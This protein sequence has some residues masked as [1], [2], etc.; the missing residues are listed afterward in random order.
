[1]NIIVYVMNIS[2]RKAKYMIGGKHRGISFACLMFMLAAVLL[3]VPGYATIIRV[4]SMTPTTGS[5]II[6]WESDKGGTGKVIYGEGRRMKYSVTAEPYATHE[7][8]S[9]KKVTKY[10]AYL[11]KAVLDRLKPGTTYHYIVQIGR[12]ASKSQSFMTGPKK[13]KKLTFVAYGDSR[14][15]PTVHAK[16]AKLYNRYKP[17]F[18]MHCGDFVQR[19]HKYDRWNRDFFMPLS[20]ILDH[21]P[22]IPTKGNHER[23]WE[24]M[25]KVM[26]MP[27]NEM[28]AAYWLEY[29]D[30]LHILILRDIYDDNYVKWAEKKLSSSRAKWKIAMGHYPSFNMGGH[31]ET[32]GF[33]E[34][35]NELFKKYRVDIYFSGDSHLYERFEPVV[36]YNDKSSHVVTYIVT[37]GGGASLYNLADNS[38][39]A[40]NKAIYHFVVVDI[41]GNT[42]TLRAID[43]NGKEFDR[44]VIKKNNDGTVTAAYRAAAKP[45]EALITSCQ[46]SSKERR[47]GN[48]YARLSSKPSPGKDIDMTF[49]FR[50]VK[51]DKRDKVEVTIRLSEESRKYYTM[52]PKEFSGIVQ[53][54]KTFSTKL[55]AKNAQLKPLILECSYKLIR[56]GKIYFEGTVWTQDLLKVS[57]IGR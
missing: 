6:C 44:H 41:D 11:Y 28:E 14:D 36:P 16:L 20:G 27:D 38:L 43:Q 47:E 33:R 46:L 15:N 23:S 34:G 9:S 51:Y 2:F 26:P 24:A 55:R 31:S 12:D 35:Y 17:A 8:A 50:K 45:E 4:F 3:P 57:K 5:I 13:I 32:W 21:I 19:A 54:K 25:K 53:R 30:D 1:M 48:L 39:L 22:L 37:A 52:T 40:V 7:N 49:N 10:T 42:L 56:G 18:I 29:S